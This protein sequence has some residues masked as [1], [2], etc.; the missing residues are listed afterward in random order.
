MTA[1]KMPTRSS[2]KWIHPG[3]WL[4]A[5]AGGA[6]LLGACGAASSSSRPAA[7]LAS[8]LTAMRTTTVYAFDINPSTD[9]LIPAPGTHSRRH[10]R[11]R[12]IDHQ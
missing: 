6:A 4:V 3:G 1:R 9:E 7:P 2:S 11:R 5:L 12:R 8:T 10:L